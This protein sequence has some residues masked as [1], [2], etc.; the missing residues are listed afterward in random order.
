MDEFLSERED[1][2]SE[3]QKWIEDR[4]PEIVKDLTR[5]CRIRSVAETEAVPYPPYG[6]GCLE[7]LEEMLHM[8]EENGFSTRN[9]DN[10]V[11]KISYDTSEQ[12]ES[13]GIWAHLDVVDEG[14]GWDYDLMS[15]R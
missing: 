13:I 3:I 12:K 14:E 4:M 1:G 7:V 5:I 15:R 11:G 9:Y 6:K 10:Y 2:L 8:G